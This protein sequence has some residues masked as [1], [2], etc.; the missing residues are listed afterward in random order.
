METKPTLEQAAEKIALLLDELS[1]T[2]VLFCDSLQPLRTEIKSGRSPQALQW[3][4]R[5]KEPVVLFSAF[6]E[7]HRD[8]AKGLGELEG[9]LQAVGIGEKSDSPLFEEY[10]ATQKESAMWKQFEVTAQSLLKRLQLVGQAP[11]LSSLGKMPL[12][13]DWQDLETLAKNY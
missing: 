4:E 9:L 7:I 10:T 6:Q 3:E 1:I 13:E 11:Q 5:L 8:F 12:E 2:A